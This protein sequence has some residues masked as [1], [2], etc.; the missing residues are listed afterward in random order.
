MTTVD[1]TA[2]MY[3]VLD[4][5]LELRRRLSTATH[6]SQWQATA[7]RLAKACVAVTRKVERR[8]DNPASNDTG[9]TAVLGEHNTPPSL[10]ER[11]AELAAAGKGVREIARELEVNPST[12]SRRL[13]R[14][15]RVEAV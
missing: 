1:V 6:V 9:A 11:I 2:E 8:H 3:R 10:A 14:M 15:R 5:A 4:L 12:V 13:R 7:D